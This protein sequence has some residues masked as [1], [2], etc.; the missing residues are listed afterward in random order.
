MNGSITITDEANVLAEAGRLFNFEYSNDDV[1]VASP[2]VILFKTGAKKVK[3]RTNMDTLGSTVTLTLYSG[4]TVSADGTEIVP[5]KYNPTAN[6]PAPAIKIYHTPTKT[7]NG[8]ALYTR[9]FLGYS[10]GNVV[11]GASVHG[12]TWRTLPANGEFLA[13]LT[14]AADDTKITYGGCFYEVD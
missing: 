7:A 2:V 14:P 3:Y 1:D 5:V 9:K 6:T 10:Q 4:P 12:S 13:I 8:T 11:T